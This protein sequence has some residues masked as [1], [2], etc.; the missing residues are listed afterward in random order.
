MVDG[1]TN[2]TDNLLGYKFFINMFYPLLMLH[3]LMY[4]LSEPELQLWYLKQTNR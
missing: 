1:N 2:V 4:L 3:V